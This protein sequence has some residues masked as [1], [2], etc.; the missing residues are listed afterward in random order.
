[1]SKY[2]VGSV[3]SLENYILNQIHRNDN[4]IHVELLFEMIPNSFAPINDWS[5]DVPWNL[6]RMKE[7]PFVI[8]IKLQSDSK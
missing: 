8:I 5:A 1:M 2:K 6:R 3:Q 4:P 7:S